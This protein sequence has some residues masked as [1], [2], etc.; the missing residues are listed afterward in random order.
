[1]TKHFLFLRYIAMTYYLTTYMY[2]CVCMLLI[3]VLHH[4]VG[5]LFNSTD[6]P[7]C[8][9]VI[10]IKFVYHK[11]NTYKIFGIISYIKIFTGWVQ[12]K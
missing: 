8:E 7:Y 1:M 2:V 10:I 5:Y 12:I 9:A 11:L 4:I 6:G 3:W